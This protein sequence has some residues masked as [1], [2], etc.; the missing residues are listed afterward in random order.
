MAFHFR[1]AAAAAVLIGAR[2]PAQ[3]LAAAESA[4]S[5]GVPAAARVLEAREVRGA[6]VVDGR[7]DE[8]EWL[9]A[10]AAAGFIQSEPRTGEPATESTDVRVLYD[11]ERLYIGAY[12]HDRAPDDIVVNDIRKDFNPEQQDVF[13]VILDTFHDRRNGYVFIT[14]LAGARA[15]RQVANE[16]REIN[17]SWDGMW[18]VQTRRVEDGWMVEMAIPFRTLRFD[19]T[20][21]QSW[22][23]NFSRR[24]RRRNEVSFWAPVPRAYTLARVSLAG[25]LTGIAHAGT[26]RD[27]RVKPY[28]AGR[29]TR[30]TGGLQSTSKGDAGVDVKYGVTPGLTLDV[31]VNPDFAQAEA[32]EQQVNLTQFSQFFPEKREFFLENSGIFYVGDA[33]RN[34]RVMLA[35]TPD[36][37]ML[38]FFSRR[39]GLSREG[40]NVAIPAGLR[41]TGSAA[42][43]TIGALSMRTQSTPAT[44]SNQY[45]VLRLRRNL[46]AGSDVGLIVLDR[47]GLGTTTPD[48]NRVAGVDANFRLPGEWDWNSYG[49]GSRKPG[50]SGGQYSYRSSISHEGNFF[51]GKVGV[52]EIGSGFSDDV[53]YFR[54]TDTRKYILDVGVRPRPSWLAGTGVREMHPHVVWNYYEN[55]HREMTAKHL[56]SGYTFFLNDGGFMEL[57]VNPSFQRIDSPFSISPSVPPLPAGSYSWTDYQLKGGTNASRLLSASY[58]F[59]TGGLWSGRQR[60]QQVAVSARPTSQ[61]AASLG[62]S[63]TAATLGTPDAS[64]EALL[65]TTR[66]NYSFTTNM[67]FDALA[68]YD[69]RQHL[70]NANLRFNVIHHP[71]SDLFIV[72]NQQR[73]TT[74]DAPVPGF[75]V[76]VKFTQ[77]LSL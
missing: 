4:R 29:T 36:E 61:L 66:A 38:L 39:I 73:I 17:T 65:W 32:D 64:F 45:S 21:A 3:S 18:T 28:V 8:P 20:R 12:L 74:P 62:V 10:P 59:I 75:G 69:P 30:E 72:L 27:L 11:A 24:I 70:F 52:L 43:A 50:K 35:P 19:F 26:A 48:W 7:L 14:N 71:L 77:M 53:G 68:Q 13:E 49:V 67:F 58:T 16:G 25:E 22:G 9:A 33:A 40:R 6:I 46:F 51:H 42:G 55:L 63:H 23:I 56:H 1:I 54:R 31:T 2:L 57:S 60:T 47:E 44:P 15:D 34:N 41:L 76:I 5:S 37:D